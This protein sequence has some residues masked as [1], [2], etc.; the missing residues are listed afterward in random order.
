[1]QEVD[2]TKENGIIGELEVGPGEQTRILLGRFK[3]ENPSL[4]YEIHL[5]PDPEED[6][7]ATTVTRIEMDDELFGLVLHI[8]NYGFKQIHAEIYGVKM[9]KQ[10]K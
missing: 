6:A 9:K 10:H 2:S 3:D 7:I 8:A 5:T 1:M 4:G